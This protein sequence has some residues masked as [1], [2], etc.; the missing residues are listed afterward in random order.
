M[1]EILLTGSLGGFSWNAIPSDLPYRDS[2]WDNEDPRGGTATSV[3]HLSAQSTSTVHS[4]VATAAIMLAKDDA[5]RT[6]RPGSGVVRVADD[7][8]A[9]EYHHKN[10]E[11]S[12]AVYNKDTGNI[13][14][15][16]TN[17]SGKAMISNPFPAIRKEKKQPRGAVIG[18]SSAK[19]NSTVIM[20]A[21]L[22]SLYDSVTE[23][24]DG[25]DILKD[26]LGKTDA[27]SYTACRD[28]L[29]LLSDAVYFGLK[30]KH[31]NF[32]LSKDGNITKIEVE[33]IQNGTYVGEPISG[34][35]VTLM[36]GASGKRQTKIGKNNS[37]AYY[38]NLPEVVEY[39]KNHSVITEEERKLVPNYPDDFPVPPNVVT[40]MRAIV[41]TAD[42]ARPIC[43]M[44]W[45][46]TS[47]F[48]K[49]TGVEILCCILG[50]PL[51]KF[52]CSS[53]TEKQD[54][55]TQIVPDTSKQ[56]SALASVTFDEISYDPVGAYEKLT[57]KVVENISSNEVFQEA[58]KRMAAG[59]SSTPRYVMQESAYIQAL[60]KGWMVEVQECSRIRDA[61]VLP[62]LNEYDRPGAL[63]PQVDGS[64]A[65]RHKDAIVFF[66]DNSGYRSC[67]EL[68]PAVIRRIAFFID[69]ER[70]DKS[71]LI[72]RIKR[73][74]KKMLAKAGIK[75]TTLS[76]MYKVWDKVYEYCADQDLL[77]AGGCVTSEELERWVQMYAIMGEDSL[78]D[79]CRMCVVNK[80]TTDIE[81]QKKI[82]SSVVDTY[83]SNS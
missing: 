5:C 19:P 9:A 32:N 80:A 37:V 75:D 78:R 66:T 73:N 1:S 46:G 11:V 20:L 21:L 26:H 67:N 15:C 79:T 28:A 30:D 7:T 56:E 18:Y 12:F 50:K 54:F 42:A 23:V 58:V 59:T 10:G 29:F 53:T 14:A 76:K 36:N 40:F 64:Y 74:Q 61:G 47:G 22:A 16:V 6:F 45:R 31:I 62:G 33:Q 4:L 48:G 38:K 8:Y 27:A 41:S 43:Q 17:G 35:A 57:G 13:K 72:A 55:L 24:K 65:T 52:T 39:R 51:V 68:D 25:I 60:K 49:S 69:S 70:L 3:W 81:E 71:T 82:M 83:L 77:S 44:G 63:I 2:R 34:T